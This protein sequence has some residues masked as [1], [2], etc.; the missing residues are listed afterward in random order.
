[1]FCKKIFLETKN[2]LKTAYTDT[3]AE[4]LAFV[5]LEKITGLTKTQILLNT[6]TNFTEIQRQTLQN[7]ISRLLAFEP[8]QYVVG[9]VEF[10]GLKLAVNTSVLIPR[11]ETEEWVQRLIQIYRNSNFQRILDIGTGS[12]CISIALARAFPNAEITAIDISQESLNLALKNSLK[13]NV[14][15]KL[16][17]ADIL[18]F[19]AT[20]TKLTCKEWDLIVSNPPYVCESEKIQMQTNVLAYE[21]SEAL[22]VSDRQ[23]LIFY[24]KIAQFAQRYLAKSGILCV[25]INEKFGKEVKRIFEKVGLQNI[26]IWQDFAGKNRIVIGEK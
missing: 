24:E 1:M 22:F 25:E 16:L 3:E 23:P 10:L 19:E 12:G 26:A 13:N 2:T 14:K 9:E 17:N 6:E 5:L 4:F 15:L 20:S 18:N 21:P 8:W 11:P 7:D